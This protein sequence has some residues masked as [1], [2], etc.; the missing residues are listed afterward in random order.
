VR[1]F[2]GISTGFD[3]FNRNDLNIVLTFV[4]NSPVTYTQTMQRHT[5]ERFGIKRRIVRI[6]PELDNLLGQPEPLVFGQTF[7]LFLRLPLDQ[8]RTS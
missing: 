5:S 8:D 4:N 2:A 7:Q 1:S 3:L 6:I